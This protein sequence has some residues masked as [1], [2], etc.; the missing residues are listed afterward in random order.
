MVNISSRVIFLFGLLKSTKALLDAVLPEK[1]CVL[2]DTWTQWVEDGSCGTVTRTRSYK[3]YMCEHLISQKAF[4]F[5]IFLQPDLPACHGS[6]I[7]RL[8]PK[9]INNFCHLAVS[10]NLIFMKLKYFTLIF[11]VYCK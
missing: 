10:L 1:K 7:S 11:Q 4:N 8:K 9:E 6:V 3:Y 2:P 5:K